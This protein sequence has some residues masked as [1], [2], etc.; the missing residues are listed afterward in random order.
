MKKYVFSL[1]IMLASVAFLTPHK[2][3][4]M[5]PTFDITA[6]SEH[7]S[8]NVNLVKQYS[9]VKEATKTA[10]DISNNIGTA[11]NTVSQLN[12]DRAK[13]AQEKAEK[14]REE[15][16]RLK[17]LKE[18]FDRR[19]D[20]L[21]RKRDEIDTAVDKAQQYRDLLNSNSADYSD[22]EISYTTTTTTTTTYTNTGQTGGETTQGYTQTESGSSATSSSGS[23]LGMSPSVITDNQRPNRTEFNQATGT[24]SLPITSNS[25]VNDTAVVA[26]PS[27]P[28][29]VTNS[30]ASG[31]AS[32]TIPSL[33]ENE[34][35]SVTNEKLEDRQ[36]R[37]DELMKDDPNAKTQTPARK[38]RQPFG[39]TSFYKNSEVIA[40]A[41]TTPVYDG[42][43]DGNFVMSK[44]LAYRCKLVPDDLA[45]T[46][47][48]NRCI[49]ERL[50]DMASE[51]ASAA[52]DGQKVYSVIVRE[53]TIGTLAEIMRL[54][55]ESAQYEEY[56]K[57]LFDVGSEDTRDGIGLLSETNK[58]AVYVMN[59]LTQ[60][61]S[62][63]LSLDAL[64]QIGYFDLK[65]YENQQA[66]NKK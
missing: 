32:S 6:I 50:A 4:A 65:D 52:A 3:N 40:M 54:S 41:D 44:E 51:N 2:A 37:V 13:E 19:K 11:K 42:M 28:N 30:T 61:M 60:S 58:Q 5:F 39:R 62:L 9:K 21:D 56:A 29:S 33:R 66:A 18:E 36:N 15:V 20:E 59:R 1:S 22:E 10:S 24:A 16:E 57:K 47:N 14:A 63:Q 38:R 48:M 7:I 55:N 64:R 34:N 12:L 43:K 49:G 31:A 17:G 35:G 26:V 46:A 8:S 45:D 53:Q 23:S 25:N 27:L